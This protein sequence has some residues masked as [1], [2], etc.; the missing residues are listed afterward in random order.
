M[1]ATR[2]PDLAIQPRQHPLAGFFSISFVKKYPPSVHSLEA[3]WICCEENTSHRAIVNMR[4]TSVIGRK[5]GIIGR[6]SRAFP[7]DFPFGKCRFPA[8]KSL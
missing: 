6:K 2:E 3:W 8:L 1:C 4:F 7:A 5:I